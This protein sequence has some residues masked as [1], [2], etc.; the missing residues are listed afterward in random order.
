MFT[1]LSDRSE[2]VSDAMPAIES[3]LLQN[4]GDRVRREKELPG[5]VKNLEALSHYLAEQRPDIKVIAIKLPVKCHNQEFQGRVLAD[6]EHEKYLKTMLAH[7]TKSVFI[8]SLNKRFEET[9]IVSLWLLPTGEP[10]Q[11]VKLPQEDEYVEEEDFESI[12]K[13]MDIAA[14]SESSSDDES[15]NGSESG[16][17]DSNEPE[18]MS[19]VE[20]CEC[21]I[22]F[23]FDATA[24]TNLVFT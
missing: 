4:H 2:S 7:K 6:G 15:F 11:I 12:A 9:Q 3:I 16:S 24:L 1:V 19:G 21:L 5:F 18:M 8:E 22:L 13:Q 23:L 14:N 20:F 10:V 17:D